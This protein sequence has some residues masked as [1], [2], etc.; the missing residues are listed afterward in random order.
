[1]WN[2]DALCLTAAPISKIDGTKLSCIAKENREHSRV[3]DNIIRA[4]GP[5]TRLNSTLFRE[6]VYEVEFFAHAPASNQ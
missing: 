6:I 4:R 5:T 1:V 3:I 2:K